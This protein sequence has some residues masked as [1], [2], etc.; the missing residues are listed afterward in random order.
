MGVGVMA[1]LVK[2]ASGIWL[3]LAVK[4]CADC[5]GPPPNTALDALLLAPASAVGLDEVDPAATDAL[6]GP[7]PAVAV[8]PPEVIP[9]P[10]VAPPAAERMNRSLRFE[11]Y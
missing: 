3:P 9:P 1:A 11:G 5:D 8:E 2:A 7:S 10:P 4:T 6:E